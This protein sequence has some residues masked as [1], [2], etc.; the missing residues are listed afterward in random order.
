MINC[1]YNLIINAIQIKEHSQ[2]E[3]K[4]NENANCL[5]QILEQIN[6]KMKLNH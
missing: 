2:K 6:T 3:K 4:K 5:Q 1:E